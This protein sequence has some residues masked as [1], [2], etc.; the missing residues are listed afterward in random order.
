MRKALTLA[1][2][3]VAALVVHLIAAPAEA[4]E[5]APVPAF[6]SQ[7]EAITVDVVVVDKDGR[8]VTGLDKSDFTLLADGRPQT[9][10]GFEPRVLRATK[11]TDASVPS[12]AGVAR[13]QSAAP[14]RTLA[15]VIDDV[16]IEPARM[17]YVAKAVAA[18]L[19]TKS[20]PR[21]EVT[22]LTTSGDAWWSDQMGR[23]KD[24]FLAVLGRL[25]GRKPSS[26]APDWMSDWEASRVEVYEDRTGARAASTGAVAAPTGGPPAGPPPPTP[27]GHGPEDILGR[28]V[29]RWFQTRACVPMENC[30]AKVQASASQVLLASRRRTIAVLRAV[31]RV[32]SGLA[33]ARGRKSILI[34]SDGFLRDTQLDDFDRAIDASQRGNTAVYFIDARRLEGPV[35]F[36]AA[37]DAP[38]AGGD[39]ALMSMEHDELEAAGT[40]YV[41]SATGGTTIRNTNDLLG[42][43]ERVADESSAYY[44][45]GY[46]PEKAPDGKAHKLEVKV[47]RKGVTVRARR[48]YLASAT[49]ATATPAPSPA[50]K[51][52]TKGPTRPLDPAATVASVEDAI[53]LRLAPYVLEADPKGTVRVLAV[54][55]I[56]TSKLSFEGTGD[57]R[58]AALDL[59]VVGVSRDLGKL[60][61]VDERLQIEVNAKAVGGWF[62]LSR[63][64]ELP[65]G[66]AQVRA[67]VRDV[68]SGHAGAVAER[69]EVPALNAPRLSSPFLTDRVE[70]LPG[71]HRRL[72]PLAHRHFKPRRHL[73]CAYDVYG[74][75]DSQGRAT[76]QVSGSYTLQAADGRVV[77]SGPPTMIAVGLGGTVSRTLVLPLE[78]LAAGDYELTLDV[79]DN[80]S[81][82]SLTDRERFSVE[83][84]EGES[85]GE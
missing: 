54:L 78:G 14:G 13:N 52:A 15:F 84:L 83:R 35:G 1:G 46:Q 10:V 55:E 42:G 3:W 20:D 7:A 21:D 39:I 5:A 51:G 36:S 45:L 49:P 59:T 29:E 33:G 23:G 24:D 41:A 38:I 12:E 25:R 66:V 63:P 9:I 28:V 6:S 37:Q 22:L 69:I 61:P 57:T 64:L 71:G 74:M 43:L 30:P 81:G 8:P 79:V 75:T 56:D 17:A 73:Y 72:A 32:S 31:A 68:A 34:V 16:G 11:P 26:T 60:Y 65:P 18:W 40:A 77:S 4:Q 80:A 82:R 19:E 67:L 44:L 85:K 53:P 2:L 47:D 48:G 50:R 70:T 62:T 27:A 58:K 76:L